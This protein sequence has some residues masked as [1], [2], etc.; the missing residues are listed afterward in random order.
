MHHWFFCFMFVSQNQNRCNKMIV[1]NH[2]KDDNPCHRCTHDFFVLSLC[3]RSQNQKRCNQIIVINHYKDD[4]PCHRCT[5]DFFV[6]SWCLCAQNQNR[7]NQ[8]IV[9]NHYKDDN[10]CHRCRASWP[11]CKHS[12]SRKRQRRRRQRRGNIWIFE[13]ENVVLWKICWQKEKT[14]MADEK[15]DIKVPKPCKKEVEKRWF[16]NIRIF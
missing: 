7:C 6:L 10:P 15:T 16:F 12:C 13:V 5:N 8:I 4:N 14:I 2:Y 11:L 9:I 1:I 3:L